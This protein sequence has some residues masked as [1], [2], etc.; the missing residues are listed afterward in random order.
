MKYEKILLG[1][2]LKYEKFGPMIDEH[3]TIKNGTL[4]HLVD[5]AT[6]EH[7]DDWT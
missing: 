3:V 1:N 7:S 5:F 2:Y 6:V 4:E